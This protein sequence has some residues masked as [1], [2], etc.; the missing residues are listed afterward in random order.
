MN[1]MLLLTILLTLSI[2]L[3]AQNSVT[4]IPPASASA[5]QTWWNLLHYTL[6]ISPDYKTK[7]L[8]GTNSIQFKALRS[9]KVMAIEF[10]SPMRI[11][12]VTWNKRSLTFTKIRDAYLINFPSDLKAGKIET[13]DIQFEGTPRESVN[14]PY[15]NG[16]IWSKDLEG[17]PWMNVSCQGEGA[18]IWFPCKGGLYDEPDEGVT[19]TINVPSDF[20]AVANGELQGKRVNKNGNTA[21]T[22]IVKSPI[23]SYNIIP[24]IGK[25][26]TW[27][28]TYDGEAGKLNVYNWVLDYNMKKG[29]QHLQQVDTMLRCF[30][31]WL[32]KYPF[33]EDGYKIVEAPQPGME[34]QSAVAYGNGF[35]NGFKGKD[36]FGTGWG[37]KWD[38]MIVHE[39]GHEWFGNSIT[40]NNYGDT[41]IHEGFT[42]YLETLYTDFVFGTEAGNEYA[43]G[44][45]ARIK[46]DKPILGTNTTDKYYK[47][48]AMLHM[49]RQIVGDSLFRGWLRQMNS[50]FYHQTINTRQ[51]L[52]SLNSF[53]KMD[54]TSV[55]D[56]YLNS[57]QVPVLEYRYINDVIE[58]RWAECVDSFSM[59]VVASF[60]DKNSFL[61][62]PT[63]EWKKM[64]NKFEDFKVS[65]DFYCKTKLVD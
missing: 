47:G 39:S 62:Y 18:S 53:M 10:Q 31:Y 1:R 30:E 41:W 51:V 35:Q 32:G 20:V 23:N 44:T 7:Y 46:N 52:E 17:R 54:F 55:F 57:T 3:Q 14:P 45:W 25:Y 16:W 11:N 12:L 59:P 58:Y 60:G 43:R 8:K 9:A 50:E 61:I 37:L 36:L 49:I 38:F 29:K 4:E 22:W 5:E 40:C 63:T 48:S 24:Y 6:E 28:K 65:K 15:D 64:E 34:H 42:K 26:V 13:I 27:K 56:Q 19:F 2:N 33:Y 21:F